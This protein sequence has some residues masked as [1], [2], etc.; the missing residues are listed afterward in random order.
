ML[1]QD[2]QEIRDLIQ[3]HKRWD[4][5]FA[6][7]GVLALMVGVLTFMVLFLGMV[8]DGL[9]RIRLEFFTN[10]PSRRAE[11]AGILSAWVG[12]TLVML[13]TAVAA[14][15]VGVAA[16]VYLEEYAPRNWITD[17]IEINITNLAGVPSIVYGLLALGLFVYTFGFGQSILSAGLTLA[18]LILPVVV[19]ATRESI[20]AIPGAIREGAYA[21]G[22]TKWQTTADHI[23]PYSAPGIMTG[24]IIGMARA[25]G[26]TAPVITIGALT[27]IAFL[28]PAPVKAEAP[29]LSFE[30]LF[31]GFTVMPIQMFNWTSRPEA[32]FHN[33]AAAAGLVLVVMTLS[34]NAL[35]IWIRY[36][37]RKNIK[38]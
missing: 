35:A 6:T 15:P 4:L 31:S 21:L 36:R 38:W 22:A 29:F 18:L 27:F 37:L 10:F 26:E 16:A 20:R 25:I 8:M 19:V 32:A 12:T 28:P 11:H 5:F 1:K 3:R 14:I 13:V 17:V 23:L 34:M 2:L 33:N 9:P 7:V 24:I 30:W